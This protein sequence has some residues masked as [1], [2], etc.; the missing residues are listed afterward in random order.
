MSCSSLWVV[1]KKYFGEELVEYRNSWLFSPIAWDILLDKYL[2]NRRM[3][4]FDGTKAGFLSS[5]MYDK[6]LNSDL[7]KAINECDSLSDRICWEMGNQQIFFIK[8]KK[9][10]ADG[11]RTFLEVNKKYD[12]MIKGDYPLEQEHIKERWLEIANDIENLSDDYEYFIFKNTSCDDNVECWFEKYNKETEE[13]E[14]SSLKELDKVVTE[15][16]VINGEKMD[17]ISNLDYFKEESE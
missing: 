11:I 8:D 12:R 9:V 1:D 7:N 14:S 5:V 13:Y 16:V 10:V 4:L 17:F 6:S 3:E 15:F 2:P